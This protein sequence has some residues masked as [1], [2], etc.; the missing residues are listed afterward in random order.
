MSRQSDGAR[1]SLGFDLLGES[2]RSILEELHL[3]VPLGCTQC[4]WGP[5]GK[6]YVQGL[7]LRRARHLGT[8]Y[9]TVPRRAYESHGALAKN[10][11]ALRIEF[12][13]PVKIIQP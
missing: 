9:V 5:A 3:P 7:N 6:T 4:P 13:V 2:V 8:R 1:A 10:Q 11:L 12:G